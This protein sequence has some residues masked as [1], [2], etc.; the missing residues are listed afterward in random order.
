MRTLL[1]WSVGVVLVGLLVVAGCGTPRETVE[2]SERPASSTEDTTAATPAGTA[3]PTDA[4]AEALSPGYD[5]VKAQRFDRGKLWPLEQAPLDYFRSTYDVEADSQWL[6]KAQRG[7]LRF[8]ENCSA[9]FVSPK[10]LVL[11]NHHCARE[12]ISTAQRKGESLLENGF[13]ADSLADERSVPDL[14][15]EQ[16][17]GVRNVTSRVA[18]GR[19]PDGDRLRGTRQQRANTLEQILTER[20]RRNDEQL[21]VEI[22]ELYHGAQYSAYT[23]RRH[24][25]VRLVMA[26]E[27]QLGFFGGETDNFTYPR[28]S[29]DVAFFRV[30]GRDGDPIRPDHHFSWDRDGV[31]RG[32]PVFVVGNPGSTSRLD[33]V[34]QWKYKRDYQLPH[35]LTVFRHRQNLLKS[36]IANHPEEASTY[37][38]R[39]T[40]FSV[41]NTIK[42]LE[43]QLAGLQDSYLL[44]R[45][46]KA[47]QNLQDSIAA[48][49]SLRKYGRAVQEI[50]QLQQSKR[51]QANKQR[52]VSVLANVQL[53]SRILARAVHGYYYDFLQSRGARPDRLQDIRTDAEKIVDWPPELEKAFLATQL[54]ELQDAFG[55][56][57]PTMQKLFRTHSPDS[58]AAKLVENSALM[59]STAFLKQFDEGYLSSDDPSVSVVEALAPLFQNTNRQMQNIRS[60]EQEM[61]R[62]LSKARRAIYGWKIPPEASFSLR[63]S[64]GV[65]K[66]YSHNGSA[67]PPF[68]N[69]YGLYDRYYSHNRNEWALPERWVTPPD[70]FD[71]E[72]PLNLVSTN[73]I[74]GGSSGS[75]LLNGDLEIVGV[76][77]DSNMQALPNEYLYR[78]QEARAIS[79]DGRGILEALDDMYGATRLVRE[80]T[81]TF[82]SEEE[83]QAASSA[84]E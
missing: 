66:G 45:R 55:T 84:S 12:A 68:T 56:G 49:D 39:N 38:L 5:T 18:R 82:R 36:Y 75:P 71:L 24:E 46:A 79:V 64:D 81:G 19:A 40:L 42:S 58:L 34:S 59:D 52:A 30:Y 9:S 41:Q 29:L 78:D 54:K 33:M 11:T 8:G 70:S 53:G 62:R 23:Y 80:V 16:L 14:H 15:V 47:I 35:R 17:V 26:P 51:I 44:A 28:Y 57:H 32:E 4:A 21:R 65:V 74:S 77:F 60:T 67:V 22:V 50:E 2:V 13:Y 25:D 37:D 48:V 7:A 31:E 3:A 76:A 1:N 27:L 10:G 83:V 61:N 20:A 6:T 63:I 69:F 43:G 73:D 72:T